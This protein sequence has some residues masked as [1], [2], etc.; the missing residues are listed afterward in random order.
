MLAA[1]RAGGT[2]G[3]WAQVVCVGDGVW[4]VRTARAL[5]LP[6]VGIAIRSQAAAL[7]FAGAAVVLDDL[8]DPAALLLS[9]GTAAVPAEP[10]HA[11][12]A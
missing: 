10:T 4:D 6:F 2:I 1:I 7:R 9:L 8:N 5:G 12:G 3:T 11:P